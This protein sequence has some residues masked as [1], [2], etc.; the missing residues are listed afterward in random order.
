MVHVVE[1]RVLLLTEPLHVLMVL[2]GSSVG[3]LSSAVP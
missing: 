3:A 2:G 1:L